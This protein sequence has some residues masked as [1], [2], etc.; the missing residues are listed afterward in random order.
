MY[1]AYTEIENLPP[2]KRKFSMKFCGS[3]FSVKRWGTKFTFRL[4]YHFQ[5]SQSQSQKVA[6][7][8]FMG[9]LSNFISHLTDV[10]TN[11]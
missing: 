4:I 5:I 9:G 11:L 7:L 10:L 2:Q 8:K 1:Q 6:K 3:M